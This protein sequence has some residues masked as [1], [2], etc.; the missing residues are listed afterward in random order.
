[1]A[2]AIRGPHAVLLKGVANALLACSSCDVPIK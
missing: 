1:M 2:F